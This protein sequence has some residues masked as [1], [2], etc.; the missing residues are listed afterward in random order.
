VLLRGGGRCPR[1][2]RKQRAHHDRARADQPWRRL[3]TSRWDRYA[4]AFKRRN[5]LCRAC[6]AAGRVTATSVVNHIKPARW[7]PELF[8]DPNNHE[9]LCTDCHAIATTEEQKLYAHLG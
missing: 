7:F 4:K 6:A 3:Y 5:P 8:W 9:P 2:K 1:C